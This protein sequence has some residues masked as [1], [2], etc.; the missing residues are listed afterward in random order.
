M[1]LLDFGNLAVRRMLMARGV[2]SQTTRVLGHEVHFYHVKGTGSGPP[3]LLV[4][5]LGSSANAFF[6]TLRPLAKHFREVYAI[7]LPG[8]GF[9]PL[10]A[11]GPLPLRTYVEVLHAFRA[12]VIGQKV[13]LIGNSLGGAMAFY[14]AYEEPEALEALALI[15]P[16]GAKVA[17]GRLAITMKSFDVTTSQEAR[18]LARKLFAKPS[19]GLLLFAGELR[20]MTGSPAVQRIRSEVREEDLVSEEML[21]ALK[22]PTLLIW[23]QQEKLLPYESID[24]YRAHLPKSAQVQEVREFGHMPQMEHPREF[25]KRISDFAQTRGLR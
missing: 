10:P 23:G 22:M 5:G 6:R 9:S 18:G 20:H 2:A 1:N 8:N 14:F 4:H 16:A 17:P 13:F 19:L 15:S 25:V 24:Y 3:L 12:Q 7:D 21:A 11:S